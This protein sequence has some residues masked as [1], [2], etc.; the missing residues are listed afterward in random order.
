MIKFFMYIR[1]TNVVHSTL[2]K[3]STSFLIVAQKCEIL[4]MMAGRKIFHY[5]NIVRVIMMTTTG[6]RSPNLYM[7]HLLMNPLFS[8]K[9]K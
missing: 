4:I 6:Q 5:E 9:K 1:T 2:F 8:V 3:I 7:R